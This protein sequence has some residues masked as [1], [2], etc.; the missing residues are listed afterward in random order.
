MNPPSSPK[1]RD[2][3]P[4]L[5]R[6][7]D[8]AL[9]QLTGLAAGADTFEQCR[10]RYLDTQRRLEREGRGRLTASRVSDAERN[11]APTRDCL[12]EL[13]RWEAVASAR[14]PSERK[15][16][17][18]Y[19]DERYHLTERGH[20][21]AGIA[22]SSRAAFTD[23]VT[24]AIIEAHPYF[25]RLLEILADGAIVYPVIGEGDIA[26]GRRDGRTV[27]DWAAWGNERIAGALS[28]EATLRELQ[29]ALD[30]FRNREDKPAN[31]ELAEALNDGFAVAGFGARGLDLDGPTIKA[32][33]RWGSEL[34]VYDRSFHVPGYPSASVLWSCSDLRLD[35]N[36]DLKAMRRGHSVYATQVARAI[37]D[38]Y[39]QLAAA[40][41]SKMETPFVAIHQV[42]AQAA[43]HVGVTRALVDRVLA[44]L[45]D[46]AFADI[47]WSAAVY[48]GSTTRLPDSEPPFRYGGGRRLVM[49][50]TATDP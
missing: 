41:D 31:K 5:H 23:A 22:A 30:R 43:S 48:S 11:W 7:V 18:R 50:V 6:V 12:Q 9:D 47:Q 32:L 1:I 36:G 16:V 34:L 44:D 46:G 8:H 21:L 35:S 49:Q 15:F 19:R 25:R 38:A 29:R 27:R 33:L 24:A 4:R 37:V 39:H 28:T 42:R 3:I 13:M 14:L 10:N 40:G 2:S 26:R 17:D 20:E 45:V